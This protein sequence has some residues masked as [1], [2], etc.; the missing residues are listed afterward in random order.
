MILKLLKP[1]LCPHTSPAIKTKI[2]TPYKQ[3]DHYRHKTYYSA[4]F[5]QGPK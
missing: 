1:F 5:M 2:P 3:M 4:K